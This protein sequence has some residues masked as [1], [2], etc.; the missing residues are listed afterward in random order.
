MRSIAPLLPILVLTACGTAQER[1]TRLPERKELS[2]RNPAPVVVMAHRGFRGIAPENTLYAARKGWESG[3]EYWEL[4]VAASS[5]GELVVIHDD[6]LKRTTDAEERFPGR[7]PWSVYDFSLEELKSLD[8]GSWY[9]DAD[10]FGQ[11]AAGRIPPTE[12]ES[13]RG[14]RIP[15]LRE[16][17]LLTKELAWRVN[18]EIKDAAGRP[19]DAWIV[20][21]TAALIT[22]L[23]MR[24]SV[25]ISSFNHSYLARMKKA[26]PRLPVAALVDKPLA[27]PAATLQSLRAVAL[28]PN[29]KHL[30]E[31]TVRALREAGF[32]VLVWT[33]NEPADMKRLLDWGVTGLITDFPDRALGLLYGKI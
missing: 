12:F 17:L 30:D 1:E 9:I 33:P 24:D 13:F 22:E 26:E 4:D 14:L 32:G 10:P 28:N 15:T 20:E 31:K 27:D 23:G 25:L 16:A 7:K 8:A 6:T 18:I 21:K 11:I 2:M 29:Y 5:D 3:A 19:C